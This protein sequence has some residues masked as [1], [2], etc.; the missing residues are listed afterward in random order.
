MND[1]LQLFKL[2]K[3]LSKSNNATSKY[4]NVEDDKF[5]MLETLDAV[6]TDLRFRIEL[7][8]LEELYN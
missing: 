8:N 4:S 7:E 3:L 5:M 1:Q 2:I 6:L